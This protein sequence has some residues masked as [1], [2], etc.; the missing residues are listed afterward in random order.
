MLIA[1]VDVGD[2]V[3]EFSLLVIESPE[4]LSDRSEPRLDALDDLLI[5][6]N[7]KQARWRATIEPFDVGR[8]DL[9]RDLVSR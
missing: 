9:D 2:K 7:P 4:N 8:A 3:D 6:D 5:F 1:W